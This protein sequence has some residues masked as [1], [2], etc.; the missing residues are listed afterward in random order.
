VIIGLAKKYQICRAFVYVLLNRLKENISKIFSPKEQEK[1]ILKKELISRMLLHRMVGKSSIEAISTIMKYD[2]LDYSSVGSVSQSL[3]AIGALLP[4]VQ[5]IPIDE[6]IEITAIADEIFIGNQPILITVE[7]R[8]SVI[9]AIEL[10]NDRKKV[11]W[12]EH[13]SKIESEGKIEIVSMVTDEGTGLRSAISDKGIFWQPDT[14]HAIAHRLGKWVHILEQRAYKRIAIEY[15][16]KRVI[17]SAKTKKIIN[18]R[19]YKYNK[20]KKKTLEGIELYEN[21]LY[22]YTHI[23]KELQPFHSNG[24][25]RDRVIAKE[26][27]E[28]ALELMKSLKHEHI[29]SQITSIEKILPELLN[30]FEETKKAIQRCKKLGI[31]DETITT[32]TLAWQWDKAL[33]KAKKEDRRK[34]AKTESLFYLEYAKDILGDNYEKIKIAVFFELNSIIQASS[35]VENINSILRPYL[36]HSKNQVTQE[37]L[38]LFAYYHNHRRYKAG[39]RKGKTPMEILTGEKQDKGWIEVLTHFI[40]TVEP[41]F[42][43]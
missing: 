32:L 14:Y 39:K 24:E 2:A 21:F 6:K 15:E 1:Q 34:R 20:A 31:D 22:L 4:S 30:Y 11:T 43:V 17:S 5:I 7:P 16:R 19:R 26:K 25:I 41:N 9:L 29:N 18:Q 33:T 35:M 38:N 10:V 8:S 40:E 42:F 3:S 28:V 23:I 12:S 37:F 13:I 27:I 36:D